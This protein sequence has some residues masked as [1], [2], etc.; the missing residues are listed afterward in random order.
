MDKERIE[1]H[2]QVWLRTTSDVF[3]IFYDNIQENN[4][5]VL[6]SK[7]RLPIWFDLITNGI[8]YLL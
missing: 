3:L 8:V 4:C 1:M 5:V 6:L 7:N 2:V